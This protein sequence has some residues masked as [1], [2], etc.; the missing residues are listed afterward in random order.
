MQPPVAARD[1]G[2]RTPLHLAAHAGRARA[3]LRL[4]EAGAHVEARDLDGVTPL[5]AAVKAG[6]VPVVEMLLM[7]AQKGF[8]FN[9]QLVLKGP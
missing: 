4:I 8:D 5:H 2:G 1:C 7:G 9:E 6:A 3:S